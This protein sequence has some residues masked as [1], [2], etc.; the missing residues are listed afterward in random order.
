MPVYLHPG[1]Y[2]EERPGVPPIAGV[3]TSTAAFIGVVDT[4][5]PFTMPLKPVE[6]GQQPSRYATPTMDTP[7]LVTNFGQFVTKF[8]DFQAGNE[9]IAHSV[10]GFFQNGGT[11]CYVVAV[12][13]PAA[14][15][16]PDIGAALT[17]LGRIDDVA[18]VAMPGADPATNNTIAQHCEALKDRVAVLDAVDSDDVGTAA[19]LRGNGLGPS[20]YASLYYPRIKVENLTLVSDTNTPIE[21]WK[22]DPD[23]T[24][25]FHFVPPSGHVAGIF[26]RVDAERGVH[27]AP[28]NEVVR[29]AVG[30]KLQVTDGEQDGLN[31]VGINVIREFNGSIKVWGART[32]GGDANGE[33]KYISVRRLMNFMRESI[34]EGTQFAVFEPNNTALWQRIRRS[35]TGF[36]TLVWRDGALFGTTPEEAFYVKCDETTNPPEVRELGQVITEIG[37]AVVKPAEF[38]IFRI[39]QVASIQ[40]G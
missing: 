14:N 37:V 35:V 15:A 36:L 13:P 38:V 25:R 24:N 32:L 9:R 26:A 40:Q 2:V 6:P 39:Q 16:A 7:E 29:G 34:D 23:P 22:R 5:A 18:I 31:P 17:A 3:G 19:D 27:K 11:R 12:A 1:V 10:Y 21:Q 8:G 33:F 20:H 28:A 4:A 30:L